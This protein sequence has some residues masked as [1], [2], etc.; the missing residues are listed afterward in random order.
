MK[1]WAPHRLTAAD[2][3]R[4]R[5][6]FKGVDRDGRLDVSD[7]PGQDRRSLTV[8]A[9]DWATGEHHLDLAGHT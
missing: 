5:D 4:V 6:D 2:D 8:D 9:L 1:I 3:V 7:D